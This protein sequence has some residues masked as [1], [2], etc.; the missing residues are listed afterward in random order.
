MTDR[1]TIHT[2]IVFLGI[3]TLVGLAAIVALVAMDKPTDSITIIGQITATALG[4]LGATLVSTRSTPDP[5]PD[6]K[7]EYPETYP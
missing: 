5:H 2:V 7:P 4:A 1:R 6:P 3:I